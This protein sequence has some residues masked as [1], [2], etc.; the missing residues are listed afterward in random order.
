ME[1]VGE[2]ESPDGGLSL[3]FPGPPAPFPL[4]KY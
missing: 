3:L 1:S 4:S 2:A